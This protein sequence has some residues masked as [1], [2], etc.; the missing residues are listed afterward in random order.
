M[1]ERGAL[2]AVLSNAQG[3]ALGHFSESMK[4][5][6]DAILS[7]VRLSKEIDPEYRMIPLETSVKLGIMT[8]DII[9]ALTTAL[10]ESAQTNGDIDEDDLM[11][12]ARQGELQQFLADMRE[13]LTATEFDGRDPQ[14]D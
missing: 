3:N 4:E 12:A 5:M 9:E 8:V 13:R 7:L 11:M 14:D 1:Q 10:H 2:Y 6:Y